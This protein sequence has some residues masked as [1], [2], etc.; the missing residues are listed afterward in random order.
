MLQQCLRGRSDSNPS[1]KSRTR[2]RGFT[3]ANRLLS[4]PQDL[5]RFLPADRVYALTCGH[6]MIFSLRILMISGGCAYLSFP[7]RH[8]DQSERSHTQSPMNV[9]PAPAVS[10]ASTGLGE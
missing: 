4:G 10:A 6:R 1:T 5:E 9:T 7:R 3:R 8:H 2:R